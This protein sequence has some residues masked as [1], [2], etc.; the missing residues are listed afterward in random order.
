MESAFD[1]KML[2]QSTF[3]EASSLVRIP[4]PIGEHL[5]VIEKI[6]MSSG[7]GKDGKVWARL[8]LTYNLDSQAVKDA[9]GRDKVTL[10]Q[11]IMLDRTP[12]GGLDFSKGRN[13]TLGR[14][15]ES[16]GLNT[17]GAPFGFG[18]LEGKVLKIVVGHTPS[19]RPGA[20]P[21]DVYENVNAFVKGS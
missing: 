14:L 16:V 4:I 17:P 12:E 11:G 19:D 7:T 5:A 15:R 18:M 2:L 1:P 8:D 3:T 9:L 20:Q 6:G 10:N 13:V 21:G